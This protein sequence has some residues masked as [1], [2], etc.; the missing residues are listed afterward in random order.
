MA[1]EPV[2]LSAAWALA[3]GLVVTF[4]SRVEA[5]TG[6]TD[7]T[8][9]SASSDVTATDPEPAL[10]PAPA[11]AP[12]PPPAPPPP[13]STTTAT[14]TSQT[15]GATATPPPSHA[16]QAP[17]PPPEE[18]PEGDGR[19]VDFLW[20]EVEGGI[21]NV[22]LVAFRNANFAAGDTRVFHSVSGTGPM[23]G[24]ALGFR[25]WWL[26]VGA[27]MTFASYDTFQ[28]GT[29]GGDIQLRLP[30][31]IVEPYLRVGFG[32]AWQGGANYAD[33]LMSATTVYGWSFDAALGF[34]IFLTNWLTIGGGVGFDLLNMTRQ[35]DPVASPV[36]TFH[37]E[38]DG[39]AIGY[40]L[41]G[42]GQIGLHF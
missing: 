8:D 32:Y 28:I 9:E 35:R 21:S 39:D 17:T 13:R 42:F 29:V 30:I 11:A 14:P 38:Q 10:A 34:D 12:P 23:V 27:R 40:Q 4:G 36:T 3:I 33:P 19:D 16:A 5:Q 20:I 25:V 41:R 26:A 15:T 31:P 6:Q 18:P 7:V 37:P 2:R 1:S 24:A 22:N